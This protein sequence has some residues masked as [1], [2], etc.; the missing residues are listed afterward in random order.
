[1]FSNLFIYFFVT[2]EQTSSGITC[3]QASVF[4][5]DNLNTSL[6]CD[7]ILATKNSISKQLR[8]KEERLNNIDWHTDKMSSF[9]KA[10]KSNITNVS[11]TPNKWDAHPEVSRSTISDSTFI[12]LSSATSISRS[13]ISSSTLED[14]N[15]EQ[16]KKIKH[17]EVTYSSVQDSAIFSSQ[18]SRSKLDHCT[19]TESQVHRSTLTHCTVLPGNNVDRTTASTTKFMDAK[20]VQRSQLEDSVVL[21]GSTL[22][23]C[24]VRN[25]VVA[26][27]AK[28]DRTQL[29]N[30]SI[31]RSKIDRSNVSNCDVTDCIM[32][33]TTFGWMTLKYGIWKN[34]DLVGRTSDKEVVVQPRTGPFK[35]SES[36]SLP[37]A[38]PPATALRAASPVREPGWKAAEAVCFVATN[39]HPLYWSVY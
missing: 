20:N 19:V 15:G 36:H 26:D 12:N 14:L 10:R 3:L 6:S 9:P 11:V 7:Q 21:G 29:D 34:G 24:V 25:S 28:C 1:M 18:I 4:W 22:E 32:D 35:A 13:T 37:T 8:S 39:R 2:L 31:L 38:E 30:V 5:D 27:N 17:N 23:R 16:Q 33:R